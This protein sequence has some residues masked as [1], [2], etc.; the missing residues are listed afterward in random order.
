MNVLYTVGLQNDKCVKVEETLQKLPCLMCSQ[1][2]LPEEILTERGLKFGYTCKG[3]G[4]KH[5]KHYRHPKY[6]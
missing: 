5:V 2:M 6:L 3:C 4:T 1:M